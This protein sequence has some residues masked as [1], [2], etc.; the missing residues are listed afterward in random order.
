MSNF[1]IALTAGHYYYTPG[2]RC[3]KSIDP[4]ETREWVLTDPIVIP[5]GGTKMITYKLTFNQGEDA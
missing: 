3:L 4:N 2:K 1:R 5:A